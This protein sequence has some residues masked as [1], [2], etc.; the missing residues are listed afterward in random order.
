MMGS[1]GSGWKLIAIACV[2]SIVV[3]CSGTPATS[4]GTT[5]TTA[6]SGA[7]ETIAAPPATDVPAEPTMTE[8]VAA[9]EVAATESVAET[10]T[11]ATIEPTAEATTEPT[12]V[13]TAEATTEPTTVPTAV[14]TL[15][16]VVNTRLNLNSVTE[17]QL[18]ATIPD[19]S[20][21]MVREFFEYRPYISIQQFRREIGKYVDAA[22][23]AEYELY[24]YVPVDV[25]ESD[26]E[27]LQQLPGVDDAIAASLMAGRPYASNDAFLAALAQ[28]VP[29]ADA[30]PAAGFLLP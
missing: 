17:S 1:S 7:T 22:Q 3:A 9:T 20:N 11:E 28:Q 27:T 5:D 25:N 23:V 21:R 29:A 10:A 30:A 14:P 26:A 18:L 12:T 19:F 24:V 6:Q 15:E 2:A 13:P 8:A 16:A 4:T